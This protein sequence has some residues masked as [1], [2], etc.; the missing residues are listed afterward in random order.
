MKFLFDFFPIIVFYIGYKMYD[1][2]YA[3]AFAIA[4]TFV[5]ISLFWL[6][7]RRFEKMHI[8]TLALI[9]VLGGAT[10]YFQDP[11]FIQWKVSVVNWLF[12]A[13]ILGSQ[14]IGKTPLIERMMN[15]AIS[16]ES[17][18]WVK[19]NAAWGL[20][21]IGMGFL[22]L[23]VMF[24]FEEAIWVEFKVYGLLGLTIAFVIIQSIY[25][26]K[27]IQQEDE[28]NEPAEKEI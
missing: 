24:N 3:T 8:I 25:L 11:A 6:K 18:I 26:A 14:F 22:N 23:Y 28:N 1:I 21:F 2:Y 7:N 4:A 17:A 27:H 20:F 9:T 13:V 15:H 5:Q 12:G 10:I 19:L 16:M